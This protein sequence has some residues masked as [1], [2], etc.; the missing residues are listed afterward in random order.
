MCIRDRYVSIT[1]HKIAIEE[2][3]NMTNR[4]DKKMFE[5]IYVFMIIHKHN[6]KK[7]QYTIFKYVEKEIILISFLV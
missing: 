6:I 7:R 5:D 2:I 1:K 3:A 4:I